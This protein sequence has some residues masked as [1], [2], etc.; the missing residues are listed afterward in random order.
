MRECMVAWPHLSLVTQESPSPRAPLDGRLTPPRPPLPTRRL[1]RA[2]GRRVLLG[3]EQTKP[4]P[5]PDG[6][7]RR[8][9]ARLGPE[10]AQVRMAGLRPPRLCPRPFR[11]AQREHLLLLRGQVR[12]AMEAL[13]GGRHQRG[14]DKH[15]PLSWRVLVHCPNVSPLPSPPPPTFRNPRP[16]TRGCTPRA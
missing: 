15:S 1:G 4:G 2:H 8:G 9:G 5:V 11:G 12:Q 3:A 13:R 14:M 6:G 7:L 10:R 16:S